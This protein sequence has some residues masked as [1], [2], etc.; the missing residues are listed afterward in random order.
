[1]PQINTAL[2]RL[3]RLVLILP[4][5]S[6]SLLFAFD[7]PSSEKIAEWR[8]AADNG[9]ASAQGILGLCYSEGKGVPKD[10][11]EAVNWHRKAADQ[12]NAVAQNLLANCY[13]DGLGA[14]PLGKADDL[15][16]ITA[17]V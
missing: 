11:V 8:K 15:K 6:P 2:F 7:A 17:F 9:N 16:H 5:L 14:M 13:L 10:Q 12:G 1:M 4:F 3:L